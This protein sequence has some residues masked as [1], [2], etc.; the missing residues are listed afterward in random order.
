MLF[1]DVLNKN[2]LN[3]NNNNNINNN[4]SNNLGDGNNNNKNNNLID[5]VGN[6][7][8]IGFYKFLLIYF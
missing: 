3:N 4:N 1:R 7:S 5:L 8:P 2:N 6:T